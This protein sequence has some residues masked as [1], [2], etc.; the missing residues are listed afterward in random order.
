MPDSASSPD[1][2]VSH[3][4]IPGAGSAG[5]TWEPASRLLSMRILP[6][7]DEPSVPAM[8]AALAAQVAELRQPR[9]LTGASLGGM[10]AL[11]VEK[12]VPIEGLVLIATGFGITVGESLLEWVAANPPDLFEKMARVSLADRENRDQV[13]VA[14]RDFAARGQPVVLRHL[15]ALGAYRPEPPAD[16]PP[17]LVIWGREDR[18]VPLADHVEL[19]LRYRGVLAPV[20]GAAHKP[21]FE[22]PE[23]TVSWMRWAAWWAAAAGDRRAPGLRPGGTP[24]GRAQ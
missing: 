7:P 5:L 22:R 8:A 14:A 16:P 9:V 24:P 3:A 4:V 2:A 18:S 11:E 20:A 1:S 23:E 10:V 15:R 13:A 12:L 6:V 21:F 17:T 19:A